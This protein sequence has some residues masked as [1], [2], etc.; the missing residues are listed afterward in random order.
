MLL[1]NTAPMD[2]ISPPLLYFSDYYFPMQL[3]CPYRGNVHKTLILTW[4][5]SSCTPSPLWASSSSICLSETFQ[6]FSSSVSSPFSSSSSCS[7]LAC[8]LRFFWSDLR[9]SSTL[10]S[11]WEVF[12]LALMYWGL[13]WLTICSWDLKE[14]HSAVIFIN[15]IIF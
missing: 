7:F 5:S 15:K 4:A 3:C 13:C 10:C 1:F 8:R 14:Q 6:A 12:T 11:W 9:A 2:K